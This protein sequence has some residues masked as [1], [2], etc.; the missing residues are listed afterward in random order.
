MPETPDNIT[1][2]ATLT[3]VF[4]RPEYLPAIFSVISG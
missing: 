1:P 2:S 3:S 4:I